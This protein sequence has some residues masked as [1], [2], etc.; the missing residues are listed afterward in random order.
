MPPTATHDHIKKNTSGF[1]ALYS[2][3]LDRDL[4]ASY[5]FEQLSTTLHEAANRFAH[6]VIQRLRDVNS[7]HAAS[8]PPALFP[9]VGHPNTRLALPPSKQANERTDHPMSRPDSVCSLPPPARES[10]SGKA[11]MTD[12]NKKHQVHRKT[13][14]SYRFF[15]RTQQTAKTDVPAVLLWYAMVW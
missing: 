11:P 7:R 5:Y 14:S 1:A 2:L 6:F 12:N 15:S 13:P 9:F 8:V 10:A 4:T 3:R